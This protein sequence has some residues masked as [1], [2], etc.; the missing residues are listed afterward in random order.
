MIFKV[1]G[2]DLDVNR[3]DPEGGPS[4]VPLLADDLTVTRPTSGRGHNLLSCSWMDSTTWHIE[5]EW[6]REA[7]VWVAT[8]T[9]VP[10]LATE[11]ETIEGLTSRLRTMIPELLEANGLL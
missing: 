3:D 11:A 10:G 2:D 6:D 7:G 4:D 9:D 8:S 1:T 5:A